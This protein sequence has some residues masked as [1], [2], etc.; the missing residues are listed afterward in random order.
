MSKP[1]ARALTSPHHYIFLQVSPHTEHL[2][3]RYAIQKA[4]QQTFGIT[5]AGL[6]MDIL[7]EQGEKVDGEDKDL[8]VL[9]VASEDANFVLSALP[10]WNN[11]TMR[12]IHSTP[13]LPNGGIVGK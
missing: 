7:S 12:V 9:R 2:A 11:P 8:V 4:L 10:T 3:L 6:G 5:R 1:A 13:F